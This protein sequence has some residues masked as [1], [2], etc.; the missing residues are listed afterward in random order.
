M[1]KLKVSKR[2]IRNNFKNVLYCGYCELADLL[3]YKNA[4]YYN[5]N[6]YGWRNDIYLIDNNTVIVTGYEPF[7]NIEI[8]RDISKKYNDIAYRIKKNGLKD[9][10]TKKITFDYNILKDNID[11]VIEEMTQ[12]IIK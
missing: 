4:N 3:S 2:E 10:Q 5:A 11:E 9:A 1:I 6:N 8:P 7:G 12:E